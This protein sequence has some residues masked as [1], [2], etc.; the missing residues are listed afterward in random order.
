MTTIASLP[1]VTDIEL[2]DAVARAAAQERSAT[3]QLIAL[4]TELDTRKLYLGE[5][6]SSLF[7]YCTQMLHLSEHAAYGRIAAARAA[8]RFPVVLDLLA[9][10]AVTLTTIGLLAPHLTVDNVHALLT[11][12][13][14]QSKREVERI[15]AALRPLPPVPSSV[16]KLPAPAAKSEPSCG[17]A[18]TLGAPTRDG[19]PPAPSLPLPGPFAIERLVAQRPAVVTPLAPERYKVQV[20][21]SRESYEKLRRAQDLLRHVIPNGDPAAILDRALSL[22]V[23]DLEKTRLASTTRPQQPR[24]AASG[25]RHVPAAVKR[26]VWARDRGQCAFVGTQGRCMERGFLEVHHV[27]PFAAGVRRSL[28]TWSS[29]AARTT[30]SR[31]SSSLDHCWCEKLVSRMQATGSRPDQVGRMAA[32]LVRHR[33]SASRDTMFDQSEIRRSGQ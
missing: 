29:A 21:L 12:A 2:L 30:G 6:C 13:R 22:L 7:T 33:H 5:G 4:L 11:A 19:V 1:H 3:T 8:R 10:G 20:T 32:S 18:A 27:V 24:G 28:K 15:V 9:E 23:A 26:Q 14:H 16:R 17:A 25:S 31:P